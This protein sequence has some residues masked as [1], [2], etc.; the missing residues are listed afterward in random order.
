MCVC[1][2]VGQ[3]GILHLPTCIVLCETPYISWSSPRDIMRCVIWLA[4]FTAARDFS[5]GRFF[6]L[7]YRQNLIHF[8]FYHLTAISLARALDL[9]I[10]KWKI[11]RGERP[12][13]KCGILKILF[14]LFHRVFYYPFYHLICFFFFILFIFSPTM[15]GIPC[16][17]M[18]HISYRFYIYMA[19]KIERSFSYYWNYS[20]R[21]AECVRYNFPSRDFIQ[22]DWKCIFHAGDS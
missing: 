8:L 9:T 10:T 1:V 4:R 2:C 13:S 17:F 11:A 21:H 14:L 15:D 3:V 6:R 19:N 16:V 12:L 22:N 5:F 20:F 7:F 18:F